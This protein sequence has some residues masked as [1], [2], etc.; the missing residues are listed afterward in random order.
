MVNQAVKAVHFIP[1]IFVWLLAS[2][3]GTCT[4]LQIHQ[5]FYQGD[6]I[7]SLWWDKTLLSSLRRQKFSGFFYAFHLQHIFWEIIHHET[8]W[9]GL[10]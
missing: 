9:L 10:D 1:A 2:L 7:V 8:V 6:I 4:F 3:A 5:I